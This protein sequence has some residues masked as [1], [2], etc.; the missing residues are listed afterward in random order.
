[1]PG[2]ALGDCD[3]DGDR[4]GDAVAH[5]DGLEDAQREDAPLALP[6]ADDEA[7]ADSVAVTDGDAVELRD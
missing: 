2:D 7:H 6:H 1:M 5:S 4:D 3:A